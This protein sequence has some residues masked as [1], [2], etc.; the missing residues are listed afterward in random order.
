MELLAREAHHPGEEF[1]DHF[2]MEDYH[3]LDPDGNI[4]LPTLWEDSIMPGW[5]VT[6]QPKANPRRRKVE[7]G[8]VADILDHNVT[9]TNRHAHTGEGTLDSE[10]EI[11]VGSPSTESDHKHKESPISGILRADTPPQAVRNIKDQHFQKAPGSSCDERSDYGNAGADTSED[12]AESAD[13]GADQVSE[14]LLEMIPHSQLWGE[15]VR[16]RLK[17]A[18][19]AESSLAQARLRRRVAKIMFNE[20]IAEYHRHRIHDPDLFVPPADTD[21]ASSTISESPGT[22]A[23]NLA[24]HP[25]NT[26]DKGGQLPQLLHY[27]PSHS[28]AGFEVRQIQSPSASTPRPTNEFWED[29]ASHRQL[30]LPQGREDEG[31]LSMNHPRTEVRARGRSQVIKATQ[32]GRKPPES[33]AVSGS[34][35]TPEQKI[36]FLTSLIEK[37]QSDRQATDSQLNLAL[38]EQRLRRLEEILLNH[39]HIRQYPYPFQLSPYHL[40]FPGITLANTPSVAPLPGKSDSHVPLGTSGSERKQATQNSFRRGLKQRFRGGQ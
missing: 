9:A 22:N 7:P 2:S 18:H 31:Q 27:M 38:D 8:S 17:K 11:A 34:E 21:E 15:G 12:C 19:G 24:R 32:L 20:S 37:H 36:G 5:T 25:H 28:S 40:G 1:S 33:T 30:V 3:L 29:A 16:E 6:L 35:I 26:I 10:Q 4:I 39:D 14:Y 23:G 13:N